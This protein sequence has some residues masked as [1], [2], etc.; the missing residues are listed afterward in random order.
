MT[1]E[2]VKF[3][4]VAQ[5]DVNWSIIFGD[6]GFGQKREYFEQLSSYRILNKDHKRWSFINMCMSVCVCVFVRAYV[7]VFICLIYFII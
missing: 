6:S 5:S 1:Q 3:T 2:A 4:A 7:R